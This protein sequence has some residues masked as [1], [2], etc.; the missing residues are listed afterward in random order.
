MK[1]TVE[2][3]REHE[4]TILAFMIDMYCKG[5]HKSMR[6][7]KNTMCPECKELSDYAI[8]RTEKCPFMETKTFCSACKVHCYNKEHK[9]RIR[10]VMRYCGPRMLF[11]HPILTIKHGIITIQAKRQEKE[12][13]KA[14]VQ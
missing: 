13:E 10:Q 8:F 11:S 2:Q 5:N 12:R 6:P 7:D 3:K 4:K 9:E 14:N 1:L